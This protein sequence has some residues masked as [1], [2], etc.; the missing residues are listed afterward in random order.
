MKTW[1][2]IF[3]SLMK[4]Y[5]RTVTDWQFCWIPEFRTVVLWGDG[6]MFLQCVVSQR[7]SFLATK[8][9]VTHCRQR[10]KN[11]NVNCKMDSGI[12]LK[13]PRDEWGNITT[14]Y[15]GTIITLEEFDFAIAQYVSEWS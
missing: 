8:F 3:S 14:M 5:K 1:T 2:K 13:R 6:A 9:L 4:K 12:M 15:R 11:P 10:R 7:G